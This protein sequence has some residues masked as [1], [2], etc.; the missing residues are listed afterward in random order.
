[1]NNYQPD[2]WV[3]LRLR[4]AAVPDGE[5]F[6]LLSG[7][8]GGYAGS[9]SWRLNSGITRVSAQEDHFLVE[10]HSGSVYRCV[11]DSER[12]SLLTQSIYLDL[13]DRARDQGVTVE[14]VP[15]REVSL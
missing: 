5:I 1:M 15:M 13:C 14:I 4:G 2:V 10:G 11:Q 12:T 7:W 3:V 6:K 9:D 8:Y